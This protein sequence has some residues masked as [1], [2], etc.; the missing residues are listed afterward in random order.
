MKPSPCS[1]SCRRYAV[2]DTLV[3]KRRDEFPDSLDTG[4]IASFV[5]G[6]QTKDMMLF[7]LAERS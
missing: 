7:M 3:E 4:N 2:C 1:L 5:A 6:K